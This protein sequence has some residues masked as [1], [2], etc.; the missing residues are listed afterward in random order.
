MT[1][2]TI[3]TQPD[4]NAYIAQISSQV[5][6]VTQ[7]L[8]KLERLLQ[9]GLVDKAILAEFRQAVDQIRKTSW[10]VQQSM[11]TVKR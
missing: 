9:A 1:S 10:D 6:R 4:D 5:Q 8:T 2:F 3:N 11:E 7:E